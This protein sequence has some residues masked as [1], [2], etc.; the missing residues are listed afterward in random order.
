MLTFQRN[1]VWANEFMLWDDVVKKSPNKARPYNNRG[2]EY[3]KNNQIEAAFSD[4]QKAYKINPNFVEALSNLGNVAQG[5][6]ELRKLPA[7][8]L[9]GLGL[10]SLLRVPAEP[11]DLRGG[12][13]PAGGFPSRLTAGSPD[14]GPAGVFPSMPHCSA[15]R[16]TCTLLREPTGITGCR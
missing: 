5:L 13:H 10:R 6:G 2:K 12:P 11:V 4:F 1:K 3:F 16:W 15:C 14:R 8:R 7:Y 9:A